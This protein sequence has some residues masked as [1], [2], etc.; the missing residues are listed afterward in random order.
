M[1]VF[2]LIAINDTNFSSRNYYFKNKKVLFLDGYFNQ[3]WTYN[4][5]N[6]SFNQ[7]KLLPIRLND[8]HLK[9]CND[10][11]VIHIRGGDFLK[12]KNLN[13][14]KFDYYKNSI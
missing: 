14:C 9:I 12:I 10:N 1:E 8:K 4:N 11:V 13:I 5:L 2:P 6:E 3:N 7:L